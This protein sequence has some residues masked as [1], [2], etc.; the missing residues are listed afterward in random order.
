VGNESRRKKQRRVLGNRKRTEKTEQLKKVGGF[1]HTWTGGCPIPTWRGA[2]W[3][4]WV[5]RFPDARLPASGLGCLN[6]FDSAGVTV[7][8]VVCFSLAL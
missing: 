2:A 7:T 8:L 1:R 6:T 3:W 5:S 4:S